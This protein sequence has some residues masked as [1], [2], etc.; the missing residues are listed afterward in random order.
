MDRVSKFGRG[1]ESN[2]KKD[3]ITIYEDERMKLYFVRHGETEWNTQRRF[4]GRKNSP[5]TE[6][7]EQQ[8]KNIAEV[9]RNIPFTRLYSSS[10]ERAR[11]T[12]QEIQKGR[13]IP[14]E[15]MDE[16]IEISMG[17]L[18][19]KTKSD[20]AELYPEEYEK[21]LH[22]SLDYNPQAFRGETFEEIQARLR[23]G[24]NDL[25]R[26]HE[27]EDVILVV[28]HGMTLQILFTDLRHGNLERLREEKLPENT[29]VRV[30]EYRDQKFIIQ[31][32]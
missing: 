4:Q 15:I 17:E 10:L 25:V 6:K 14:L 9:L 5:L 26:K 20:F 28:S 24:M 30:V 16:F 31:S 27:E 13:G 12:A 1:N 32:V 8:T 19:G 29:E 7:G 18:E 2:F 23:K 22:A 11:K 3:E 21:Y